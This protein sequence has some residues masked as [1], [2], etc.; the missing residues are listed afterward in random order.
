[1][2]AIAIP[3]MMN[4]LIPNHLLGIYAG[5]YCMSFAL[6]NLITDILATY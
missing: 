3:K 4:E 6:A 5:L 1:M 2:L